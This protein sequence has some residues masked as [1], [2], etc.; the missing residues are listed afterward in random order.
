M[1]L[2]QY[3]DTLVVLSETLAKC[4]NTGTGRDNY[5]IIEYIERHKNITLCC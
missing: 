3:A 5:I 1:S 4:V 2:K